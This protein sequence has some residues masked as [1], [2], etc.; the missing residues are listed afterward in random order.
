LLNLEQKLIDNLCKKQQVVFDPMTAILIAKL[1]IDLIKMIQKCREKPQDAVTLVHLP[2]DKEKRLVKRK[3]RQTIGWVKYFKEG[4]KYYEAVLSTG[5]DAT[6][7]DL[8]DAY[9]SL[10][11]E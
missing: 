2:N 7:Q 1:A 4:D 11:R 3:I 8:E 10:G 5:R 6:A 9:N